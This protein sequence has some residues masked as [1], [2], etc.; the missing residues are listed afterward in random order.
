[1]RLDDPGESSQLV[2][3]FEAILAGAQP[4]IEPSVSGL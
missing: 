3:R 1:L 2:E 4:G